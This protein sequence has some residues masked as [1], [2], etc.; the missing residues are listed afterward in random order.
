MTL[1]G[2]DFECKQIFI[3]HQ[4]VWEAMEEWARARNFHLSLIPTV[5]ADGALSLDYGPEE[6]PTYAFM[7]KMPGD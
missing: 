6:T 1:P 4:A 7:P 5:N 3:A 2:Q